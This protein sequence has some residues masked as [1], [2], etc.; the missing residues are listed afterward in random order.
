MLSNLI[1]S[2]AWSLVNA[3]IA[4]L[5]DTFRSDYQY[6]KWTR[7]MLETN[8]LISKNI[9]RAYQS[10]QDGPTLNNKKSV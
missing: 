7:D 2:L 4:F 1:I 5:H 3:R 8:H 9:S 6:A 10:K